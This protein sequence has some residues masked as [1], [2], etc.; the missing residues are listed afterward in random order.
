MGALSEPTNGFY[1][2]LLVEDALQGQGKRGSLLEGDL[3]EVS[4]VELLSCHSTGTVAIK[5]LILCS[6]P[7]SPS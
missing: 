4:F 5:L 3:S 7:K 1:L 6:N 2:P